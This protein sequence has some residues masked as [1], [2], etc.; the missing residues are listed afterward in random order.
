MKKIKFIPLFMLV[1]AVVLISCDSTGFYLAEDS[2]TSYKDGEGDDDG[3]GELQPGVITA[4]EWNDLDNWMFIDSVLNTQTYSVMPAHWGF[5]NNHRISVLVKDG[6][7]KPVADQSVALKRNGTEIWSAKTDNLGKAELWTDLYQFSSDADTTQLQIVVGNKT[8]DNV[9]TIAGD[10]NSIVYTGAGTTPDKVE[11]AFMVDATGSMGDELEFL[12]TELLD[13]INRAKSDNPT[14]TMLTGSVFYRDKGDTY[15]TKVSNFSSNIQTTVNFI[16]QQ[17]ASG[18]GDFPEAVHTALDKSLNELQWSASAR[19][20]L[21][22]LVLDAPPHYEPDIVA[23][24][25]DLITLAAE[26]GVKIIPVTASGIN[27]ETE[28]LMRFMAMSTN[29][30]YVFITNDSGVGNDHLEAT[31][32]YYQVEYL[33]DLMVRLINKYVK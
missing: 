4:G 7:D 8:F 11:I 31:V 13:V 16:K 26:K 3:N 29:G 33:N 2:L 23:T 25:H 9:K 10:V 32:G 22:F 14:V 12:K 15:L 21:L 19:T 28:F 17:K 27:K 20:R 6:F 1:L 30:T 5:Y 24:I 18:G